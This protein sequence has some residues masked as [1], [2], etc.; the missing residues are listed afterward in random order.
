MDGYASSGAA[1]LLDG[2]KVTVPARP[3]AA[4]LADTAVLREA[5]FDMLRAGFGDTV[6]KFSALNDWK[7]GSLLTRGALLPGGGRSGDGGGEPRSSGLA[8]GLAARREESVEALMAA[9]ITVGVAMS[10]AAIPA[11]P[12]AAST[13][14][15]I[16]S[17]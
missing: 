6:G 1:L 12:R 16:S 9:L 3:P 17:S 4:I 8:D 13:I 5:P 2:M 14:C 11:L 7:L 10:Y 15:P